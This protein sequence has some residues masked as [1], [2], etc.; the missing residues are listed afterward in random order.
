[1]SRFMG[2][3]L[4]GYYLAD[5]DEYDNEHILRVLLYADADVVGLSAEQRFSIFYI[6]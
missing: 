6:I 3:L 2:M 1:M 4:F 5:H